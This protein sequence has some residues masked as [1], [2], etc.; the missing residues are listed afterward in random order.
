MWVMREIGGSLGIFTLLS[1][2]GN[3]QGTNRELG[4]KGRRRQVWGR[5]G[6]GCSG[7]SSG[8][9]ASGGSSLLQRDV[10][11]NKQLGIGDL[12]VALSLCV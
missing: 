12:S 3:Q 5:T 4:C 10:L 9:V 7:C 1:L 8:S 2:E 6:A 11:V